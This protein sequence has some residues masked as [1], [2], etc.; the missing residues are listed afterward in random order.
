MKVEARTINVQIDI[1][2]W[3]KIQSEYDKLRF[4]NNQNFYKE[5]PNITEF[6]DAISTISK[7]RNHKIDKKL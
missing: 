3:A 6:F 2:E 5:H 1:E 7:N 4:G